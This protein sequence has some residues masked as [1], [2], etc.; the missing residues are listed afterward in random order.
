MTESRKEMLYENIRQMQELGLNISQMARKLNVSRNTIYKYLNT[1]PDKLHAEKRKRKRKLDRYHDEILNFLQ[2]HS[3]ISSGQVFRW[4]QHQF[5]EI[6]VSVSTVA[7][8]VRML[9]ETYNIP[10]NNV[11]KE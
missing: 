5:G 4:L 6:D 10:K 7:N 2:N 1:L 8:Y 9:R 3:D 11:C